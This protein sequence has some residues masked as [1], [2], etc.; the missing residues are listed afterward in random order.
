MLLLHAR[1]REYSAAST[2]E[3]LQLVNSFK[4]EVLFGS[5]KLWPLSKSSRS[6]LCE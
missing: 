3:L 6:F 5:E 2:A 4:V 1:E